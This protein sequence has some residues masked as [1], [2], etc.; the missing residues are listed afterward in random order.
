MDKIL[1]QT[2]LGKRYIDPDTR[3]EWK[4]GSGEG[5]LTELPTATQK[6]QKHNLKDLSKTEPIKYVNGSNIDDIT[7]S[8]IEDIYERNRDI[9]H[10]EMENRIQKLNEIFKKINCETLL[11]ITCTAFREMIIKLVTSNNASNAAAPLHSQFEFLKYNFREKLSTK[12]TGGGS[13]EKSNAR[14]IVEA[15]EKLYEPFNNFETI[16]H[17]KYLFINYFT[18]TKTDKLSIIPEVNTYEENTTETEKEL[19]SS[20][21]ERPSEPMD[22][23]YM[24]KIGGKRKTKKKK[25]KKKKTKKKSFF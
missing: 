12:K 7:D 10:I 3:E 21:F 20:P 13:K 18:N 11:L 1:C 4:L 9:T 6:E 19:S 23:P 22:K 17:L 16:D 2:Y 24:N 25:L 8:D 5:T 15:Y 14:E